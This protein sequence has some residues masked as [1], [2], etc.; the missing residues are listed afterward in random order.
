[1]LRTNAP[2]RPSSLTT[3]LSLCEV[4]RGALLLLIARCWC[5]IGTRWPVLLFLPPNARVCELPHCCDSTPCIVPTAR[6]FVA[7][8][9]ACGTTKTDGEMGL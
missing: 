1:L 7:R 9:L 2:T 8:P 5:T 3:S 6:L 4:R